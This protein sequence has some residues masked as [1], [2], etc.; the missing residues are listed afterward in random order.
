MKLFLNTT[1]RNDPETI[2]H[3]VRL[4][5][6]QAGFKGLIDINNANSII[7]KV[8]KELDIKSHKISV[9]PHAIHHPGCG[10]SCDCSRSIIK[11]EPKKY[12]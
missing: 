9:I 12:G 5:L 11:V 10:K 3:K 7:K 1:R 4:A 8:L 2:N 6:V